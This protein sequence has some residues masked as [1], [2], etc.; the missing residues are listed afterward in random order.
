MT[1]CIKLLD[2]TLRDGGYVNNWNFGNGTLTCIYDR[3][4]SA[5]VD[6]I[7]IGFLDDRNEFNIDRTIQPD[8]QSLTKTY[9]NV[10]PKKAMV[11]AMIDY[12]TCSINHVQ[13]K[14]NTFLDG[15]RVI[16]KKENMYNA[17][18]FGKQLI[19]KGYK[20]FLQLVSVTDYTEKDIKDFAEYL[21]P[22]MPMAVSIVDTYGLMHKE[23]V[24]EYFQW[25]DKY[26]PREIGIGYH[27]HN[28]FQLAYSNTIEILNLKTERDIVL[29]GTLYG[30]GKSAGNAPIELLAM[31]LNDGYG[32]SYDLNQILEAISND[33]MPIYQEHYWGY[34]LFF[35]IAAKNDCHPNYVKYLLDKKTL[36]VRDVNTILERIEPEHKL[37]YNEEYIET[38]YGEYIL[39]IID[40]EDCIDSLKKILSE[41]EI[42]LMGPGT[43][44]KTH[45]SEI[46]KVVKK[47]NPIVISTNFVPDGVKTD[48]VF[49]SNP[50]RYSLV[51]PK[52][53][54]TEVKIIGT[55]NVTA[56]DKPFDYT[57]RYDSLISQKSIWDN[58]LAILLN[59]LRKIG[60]GK[61]ALA[62]F[63]G[64]KKNVEENYIDS[65]FDLSKQYSY[66]SSV[67]KCMTKMIRDMRCSMNIEFVTESI[68]EGKQ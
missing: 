1:G 57:V 37:R 40:D 50:I 11:V 52:L 49:I 42:L 61:V 34:N 10:N 26:L 25:L 51:L 19:E 53:A 63:D 39:G 48:F 16:F 64:F 41:R 36:S 65:D 58:S 2:C 8:T 30:M 33:I 62:G 35:Y 31:H 9:A 28:N 4:T 54:N 32:K 47:Y 43:S 20:V 21:Q 14:N 17:A 67:N 38:L 23:Q 56:V 15:I 60:V 46:K 44:I 18:E 59:L 22:I 24:F 27:S 66:L 3:L 68:Y 5:G 12:G 45:A 29:D 13:P 6:I 7:E 55:S